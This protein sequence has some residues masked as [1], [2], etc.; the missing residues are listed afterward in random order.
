MQ[1]VDDGRSR[2]KPDPAGTPCVNCPPR[3]SD[4]GLCPVTSV[5]GA[6]EVFCCH[7]SPGNLLYPGSQPSV[8]VEK[9]YP[10]LHPVIQS[11]EYLAWG[12][13]FHPRAIFNDR[14]LGR[15]GTA[16]PYRRPQEY[17]PVAPGDRSPDQAPRCPLRSSFSS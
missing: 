4:S 3:L 9:P 7:R 6:L 14:P 12:G 5:S 17:E 8:E 13:R 11:R 10:R 15:K 16:L 1:V 2:G